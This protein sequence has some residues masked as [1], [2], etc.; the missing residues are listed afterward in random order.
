MKTI[1]EEFLLWKKT[2]TSSAYISY[3]RWLRIFGDL[4]D[5]ELPDITIDDI[6]RYKDFITQRYDYTSVCYSMSVLHHFFRFLEMRGYHSLSHELIRVPKK[7]DKVPISVT[8]EEFNQILETL[9]TQY[10]V[11]RRDYCIISMLWD[12]GCRIAELR[13]ILL[14]DVDLENNIAVITSRKTWRKRIIMFSEWTAEWLRIYM[15]DRVTFD[16]TSLFI[17]TGRGFDR[18]TILTSRSIERTM[19]KACVAAGITK[20][21]TPHSFRHAKAHRI[22]E[23][24]GDISTVAELL[25][26]SS[27]ESSRRYTRYSNS[28]LVE[29]AKAYL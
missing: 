16:H 26:H 24:K 22:I 15:E 8:E 7:M 13:S 2:H 11:G 5:K 10:F 29:M 6:A 12:T 1:I 23:K 27:I 14:A 20:L 4:V 17:G 28:K 18:P 3:G 19:R 9:D 21:I 25:G